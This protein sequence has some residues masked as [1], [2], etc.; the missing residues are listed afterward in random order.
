MPDGQ[1]ALQHE[2]GGLAQFRVHHD[3]A[4]E[5]DG[6]LLEGLPEGG[7]EPAHIVPFPQ[8][9]PG[10]PGQLGL[11]VV[12]D[13]VR[14]D[15]DEA[16]PRLLHRLEPDEVLAQF[17]L[18]QEH[19]AAVLLKAKDGPGKGDDILL[20]DLHFPQVPCLQF[21]SGYTCLSVLI[22]KRAAPRRRSLRLPSRCSHR[23]ALCI[24]RFFPRSLGPR[25]AAHR[26]GCPG[27]PP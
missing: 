8:Q 4:A 15:Q 16:K 23:A 11:V 14:L 5:V 22:Q 17:L 20:V 7:H 24:R 19:V 26:W 12:G 21:H 25:W 2:L 9:R 27:T 18:V 10:L 1:I 6:G 3:G 13:Q